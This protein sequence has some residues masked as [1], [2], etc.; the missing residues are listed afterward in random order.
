MEVSLDI[1]DKHTDKTVYIRSIEVDDLD[2][3]VRHKV[4]GL[5]RLYSVNLADGERLALVTDRNLA[6]S[7]ARQNDFLPVSAH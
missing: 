6:F 7:I 3:D 5:D 4:D 2:E 1:I